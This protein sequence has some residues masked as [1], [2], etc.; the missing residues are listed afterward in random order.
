MRTSGSR[1]NGIGA[2]ITNGCQAVQAKTA[3]HPLPRLRI[4][5]D[6]DDPKKPEIMEVRK[7][8]DGDDI[9]RPTDV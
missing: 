3:S 4:D 7:D 8:N 9:E 5:E 1:G 2:R 6:E